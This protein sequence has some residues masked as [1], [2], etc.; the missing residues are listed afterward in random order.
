MSAQ[1]EERI[2]QVA[3]VLSS[4]DSRTAQE[5]LSE[6]PPEHARLV[7]RAHATLGHISESE[8]REALSSLKSR[9]TDRVVSGSSSATVSFQS[10]LSSVDHARDTSDSSRYQS[11]LA[12]SDAGDVDLNAIAMEFLRDDLEDEEPSGDDGKSEAAS[13]NTTSAATSSPSGS[14]GELIVALD[15]CDI[16]KLFGR[17]QAAVIAILVQQVDDVAAAKIL[18]ALPQPLAVS[19]LAQLPQ[20]SSVRTEVIDELR[21]MILDHMNHRQGTTTPVVSGLDRIK[22][23]LA[24]SNS[25][26]REEWLEELSKID[27]QLAT[28][29]GWNPALATSS[30]N[31]TAQSTGDSSVVSEVAVDQAMAANSHLLSMENVLS[32]VRGQDSRSAEPQS[33]RSDPDKVVQMSFEQICSLPDEDLSQVVQSCEP[34]AVLV[35]LTLSAEPFYQ[36]VIPMFASRDI[37]RIK[38]RL[39]QL[40]FVGPD[41]IDQAKRKLCDVAG[42]LFAKGK[43]GTLFNLT[44]TAAA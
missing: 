27:N 7:R 33:V 1:L 37:Q 5:L 43:I 30:T 12:R 32:L 11:E 17:E 16:K 21:N 36:R 6:L 31:I 39:R 3:I 18:Q 34:N 29:V 44:I 19:A 42:E 2:R 28:C 26:P 38:D 24:A 10:S 13:M 4:V 14:I 15:S 40:D 20:V 22:S 35:L 8:R 9:V 25:T 41:E 23:I